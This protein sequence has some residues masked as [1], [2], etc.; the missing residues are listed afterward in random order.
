MG[1]CTTFTQGIIE[2]EHSS[3]WLRCDQRHCF[4]DWDQA[5]SPESGATDTSSPQ[6]HSQGH[7]HSI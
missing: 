1:L 2:T 3:R 7:R 5:A 4:C 6:Y